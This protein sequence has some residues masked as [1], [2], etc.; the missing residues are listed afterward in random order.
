MIVGKLQSQISLKQFPFIYSLSYYP[1]HSS[2]KWYLCHSLGCLYRHNLL[3]LM[4]VAKQLFL[5]FM[6]CSTGI[7]FCHVPLFVY[8]IVEK[9]A[10]RKMRTLSVR[11]RKNVFGN[12]PLCSLDTAGKNLHNHF[13]EDLKGILHPVQNQTGIH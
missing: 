3:F 8:Y 11:K 2:Q 10:Y 12:N 7:N 13:T 5:H 6:P 1:F 9:R 4:L